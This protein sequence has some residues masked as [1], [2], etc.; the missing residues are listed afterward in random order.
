[1]RKYIITCVTFV[2]AQSFVLGP[3]HYTLSMCVNLFD[4]GMQLIIDLVLKEVTF[5]KID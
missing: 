3:I 2:E 4:R 1:M 5:H